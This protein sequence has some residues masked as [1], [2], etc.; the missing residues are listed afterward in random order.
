MPGRPS[1]YP[2]RVYY[3]KGRAGGCGCG[4]PRSRLAPYRMMMFKTLVVVWLAGI[5]VAIAQS[6]DEALLRQAEKDWNQAIAE[7]DGVAAVKFMA[8]D[9]VL[10]GVRSTG[11]STVE[12]E[13]WVQSLVAMRVFSYQTEVAR[14]RVYGDSAVVSVKGSWHISFRS[15]EIDEN[16]L[17]TDVWSKRADGW[18]VVLR[19]SSPY[20]R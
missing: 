3:V 17:V 2:S 19:H 1:S 13:A 16:C 9:Y 12:R 15:Q 7:K 5:G 4:H 11:S 14:V 18:K 6:S 8:D 20:P 10:V